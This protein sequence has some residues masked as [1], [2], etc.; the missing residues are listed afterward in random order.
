MSSQKN[1]KEQILREIESLSPEEQ[2]I[3]LGV[4]EN[5]LHSKVDETEW[6]NL[7]FD[8]KKRIEESL[9]QADEGKLML[10]EDSVLYLRKKY[11]LNG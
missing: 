11:G 3:V 6:N 9:R 5:Y 8:W 1:I 10:H 7:P 4:V 2:Q